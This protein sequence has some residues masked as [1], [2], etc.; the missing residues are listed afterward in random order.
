MEDGG[1]RRNSASKDETAVVCHVTGT[2]RDD[3]QL[4]LGSACI[5][6]LLPSFSPLH[7]TL[8]ESLRWAGTREAPGDSTKIRYSYD[9]EEVQLSRHV[10]QIYALM[11]PGVLNA[12]QDGGQ[13]VVQL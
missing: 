2:S 13:A 1:G 8:T 5:P 10:R 6:S 11:G 7:P 4:A 12:R 9:L 3:G